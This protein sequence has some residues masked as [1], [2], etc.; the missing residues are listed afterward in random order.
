MNLEQTLLIN[1]MRQEQ[2]NIC[3]MS[4]FVVY[5]VGDVRA[6]EDKQGRKWSTRMP[7][8]YGRI[9]GTKGMDGNCVDC[10]LGS[11]KEPKKAWVVAMPTM[12]GNEDKV[13]LGFS[14][15]KQAIQAFLRCYAFKR[16]FLGKVSEM[17]IDKL[18]R[19]LKK[20][21]GRRL[22]ASGWVTSPWSYYDYSGFDPTPPR[23]TVPVE[24]EGYDEDD[25]IEALLR[26]DPKNIKWYTELTR[27]LGAK[28]IAEVALAEN[29][30]YGGMDGL[31]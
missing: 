15:Q 1:A 23:N 7:F 11:V 4:V 3:G 27:R 31:P 13:M 26:K 24:N 28:T 16:K 5:S 19:R 29:W 22:S 10:I 17:S 18:K 12:H 2:R 25:P 8:A 6:G 30:P 14:S 21:R 9:Q 20:R